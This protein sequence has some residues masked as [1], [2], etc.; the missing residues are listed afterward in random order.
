MPRAWHVSAAHGTYAADPLERVAG[1]H[2]QV[3]LGVE[4]QHGVAFVDPA[5]DA[6]LVAL[7]D[8]PALL[9]GMNE[10]GHGRHVE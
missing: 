1:A 9:V 4:W 2:L 5:M 7:S 8:D 3:T 6:D 10:R